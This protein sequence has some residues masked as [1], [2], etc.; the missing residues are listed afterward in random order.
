MVRVAFEHVTKQFEPTSFALAGLDLHLDDGELMALIGPSGCG[1]TT[2]L[3]ILAGFESADSGHIAVDGEI[4]DDVPSRHRDFGLVT[5]ADVMLPG[6]TA[7]QNIAFPLQLRE[8]PA[9]ETALRV[10]LEAASLR[11]GHLLEKRRS[12]LSAGE[13]QAVQVAR[14]LVTRP[15]FLLLDEPF[16][17]IDPGL[18]SRLRAD[19][20]QL[21]RTYRITTLL[22]TADQA[23]AMA[24]ADR[25]AVLDRGHLQQVGPPGDVY[26]QP[27]NTMVAHFL[28]EP[29]MNILEATVTHTGADRS[30]RIGAMSLRA[31]P[32]ITERYVGRTITLGVRPEHVV[33]GDTSRP[34]LPATVVAS[35]SRGPVNVVVVEAAGQRVAALHKGVPI[36][37]GSETVISFEPRHLHV[38]DHASGAALHHP[39]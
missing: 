33:L 11:I 4:I 24:L 35:R 38:F 16:M 37:N 22:V 1:K 6:R 12:Q 26:S 2:A 13:R 17:R 21:Q 29:G 15:R 10:E 7:R 25:I 34:H 18:A 23:D 20:A 14:S 36:R 32:E 28:G 27:V 5:S 9:S 19:M 8:R 31:Y 30:Y 3:R 39:R